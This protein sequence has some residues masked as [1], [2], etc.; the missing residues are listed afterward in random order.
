[1]SV[2]I[3]TNTVCH[4]IISTFQFAVFL[5]AF[6]SMDYTKV[7]PN[8][9]QNFGFECKKGTDSR[10]FSD[11]SM[12]S[13]TMWEF[14]FLIVQM[15]TTATFIVIGTVPM[16]YDR[17]IKTSQEIKKDKAREEKKLLEKQKKKEKRKITREQ[18]KTIYF[19]K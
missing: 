7:S 3:W 11:K 9:V 12:Q 4:M 2:Q 18:R 8:F 16:K 13:N 14:H 17:L 15:Y 6:F 10:W 1:M 5:L 19:T